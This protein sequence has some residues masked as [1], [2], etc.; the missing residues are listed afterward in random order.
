M[1]NP[2]GISAHACGGSGW[3]WNG[4][5][6]GRKQQGDEGCNAPYY[7]SSDGRSQS[8]PLLNGEV[9]ETGALSLDTRED[10]R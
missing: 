8:T 9:R 10:H 6:T 7:L 5:A 3:L 2:L 4:L 1:P